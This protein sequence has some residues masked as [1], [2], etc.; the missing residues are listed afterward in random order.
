M[1]QKFTLLEL[2]IVLAVIGILITLLLPSLNQARIRA[3]MAICLSNINQLGVANSFFLKD[4]NY[5]FISKKEVPIKGVP[6]HMFVGTGTVQLHIERP[7]N[8]YLG[9]PTKNWG[10]VIMDV[11][12]C[13]LSN[14]EDQLRYRERYETSYMGAARDWHNDDL[15]RTGYD[16]Y[17]LSEIYSPNAMVFIASTGAWHYSNTF[18][19]A[20]WKVDNHGGRRYTFNF[21]DGSSKIYK[22]T[23][24]EGITGSMER[25]QFRNLP[26][27]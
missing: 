13:P 21:V 10:N 2:L 9:G 4:H 12:V 16:P 11:A 19:D 3:K 1:K 24:T 15:D 22:T 23:P 6:G 8:K 5:R 27:N 17:H 14:E 20:Q 18:V 26:N 7:L 25:I